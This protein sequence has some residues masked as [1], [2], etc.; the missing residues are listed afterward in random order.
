MTPATLDLKRRA[1]PYSLEIHREGYA[2][3]RVYI[4][5]RPNAW[6]CGNFLLITIPGVLIDWASGAAIDL[7]PDSIRLVLAPEP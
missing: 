1:A 6:A 5:A 7:E 3:E 2:S 4:R